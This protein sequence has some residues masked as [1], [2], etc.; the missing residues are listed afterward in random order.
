M[1]EQKISVLFVCLG[2]ICRST[3]AEGV[4]REFAKQ[5]EYK[6]RIG[7]I[8]SSGTGQDLNP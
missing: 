1:P 5:P 2:N 3:M 6:D 4:F 7:K 8:D